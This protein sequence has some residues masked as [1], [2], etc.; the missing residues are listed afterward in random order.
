M[1][2]DQ[3]TTSLSSI[4]SKTA[5]V[6][7]AKQLKGDEAGIKLLYRLIDKHPG[8]IADKASWVARTWFDIFKVNDLAFLKLNLKALEKAT[9][10]PVI[11]NLTGIFVDRGFPASFDSK[12]T[13]LC[14]NWLSDY[15]R[16]TA[17]HANALFLL[18]P[19]L[20]KYPELKHEVTFICEAHPQSDEPTFRWRLERAMNFGF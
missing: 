6:Q 14:F 1:D 13:T 11:R 7:I 10:D 9:A 20:Q 17:V 3:L 15:S 8:D 12:I 18:T 5:V 19:I 2:N 4:R 16:A